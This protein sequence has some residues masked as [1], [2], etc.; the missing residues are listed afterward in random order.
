V[1]HIVAGRACSSIGRALGE[2]KDIKGAP[3][4]QIPSQKF[5]VTVSKGVAPQSLQ[6]LVTFVTFA[7][8]AH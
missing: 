5:L 8:F 2:V 3:R 1:Q 7:A 6:S 4:R